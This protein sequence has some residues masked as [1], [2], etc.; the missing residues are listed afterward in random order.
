MLPA[1]LA[2]RVG[3]VPMLWL[4][5]AYARTFARAIAFVMLMIAIGIPTYLIGGALA[6]WLTLSRT[7]ETLTLLGTFLAIFFGGAWVCW[8]LYEKRWGRR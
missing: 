2:Y 7:A 8:W 4:L 3:G 6:S 1:L 5:K